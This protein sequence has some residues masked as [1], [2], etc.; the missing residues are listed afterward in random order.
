MNARVSLQEAQ[1]FEAPPGVSLLD[2]AAAA[3]LPLAH[4]CRTG[5]CGECKLRLLQGST[6]PLQPDL[7][8]SPDERA[9]GWRLSCCEAA[10]S[11]TLQ[12]D[13]HALP[14]LAGL[15]VLTLP[16]RVA[17]LHKPQPDLLLLKLRLP[18]HHG[19]RY[20]PGQWLE[21]LGP[22]GLSRAYSVAN[23]DP[24]SDP[25]AQLELHIRKVP[26]G[27]MSRFLFGD[28]EQG[29]QPGVQPNQLLRLR[30]PRGSFHLRDV[31][32]KRLLL[33]ATG[34]GI[35][36]LKAM[37]EAMATWAPAQQ[38]AQVD[39][40][41]G[42]RVPQDFYWEPSTLALP[43][44]FRFTPVASR[45]NGA[46]QGAHGHVQQVWA[47]QQQAGLQAAPDQVYACGLPAMI[48]A[49]R[50][51]FRHSA[52]YADAFLPSGATP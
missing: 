42:N 35:A 24:N 15:R 46:W 6:T 52:F 9:Q 44:A 38:P 29:V 41:W 22:D 21:L 51:L 17:S 25:S 13:A 27:A 14:A 47:Q 50:G 40:L 12:L 28:P 16:A 33:L 1:S 48:E 32:G 36:P 10:G 8:L 34:T 20:L 3:G 7:C 5:R 43:F 4:S 2:A 23:A 49:A 11:D 30:G 26:Q 31:A 45:A 19:L 37:L 18:P 39:L